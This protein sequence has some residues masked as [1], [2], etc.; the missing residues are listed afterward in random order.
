MQTEDVQTRIDTI[1]KAMSGRTKLVSVSFWMD[2]NVESKVYINHNPKFT[3]EYRDNVA[4][5]FNL[6]RD[7]DSIDAI[8]GAAEEWA[9]SLPT[10]DEAERASFMDK[11]AGVIEHGRRIGIEDGFVN[12]LVEMMKRLSENALTHQVSS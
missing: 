12:P 1:A 8:L 7:G 4:M 2:A 5:F 3:D 10:R 6:G 9:A 11:L